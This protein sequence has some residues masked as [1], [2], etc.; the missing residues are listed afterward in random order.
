MP[1][2]VGLLW[3]LSGDKGPESGVLGVVPCEPCGRGSVFSS[4]SGVTGGQ[5]SRPRAVISAL[6]FSLTARQRLP[7]SVSLWPSG[8]F[9]ISNLSNQ[10]G[11]ERARKKRVEEVRRDRRAGRTGGTRLLDHAE[12]RAAAPS[13]R[14]HSGSSS[15]PPSQYRSAHR[16][17]ETLSHKVRRDSC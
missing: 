13:V 15:L 7:L 14:I 6:R 4:R 1:E 12:R 11:K 2:A 17:S 8:G 5:H 9:T 10:K 3:S 16:Q